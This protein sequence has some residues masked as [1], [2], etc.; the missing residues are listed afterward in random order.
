MK[1]GKKY[2]AA[3][4]KID[5]KKIYTIEEACAL[6]KETSTVLFELIPFKFTTALISSGVTLSSSDLSPVSDTLIESLE[7]SAIYPLSIFCN[8]MSLLFI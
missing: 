4:A 2:Q 3:L 1:K 8:D 6:V 5:A 7:I